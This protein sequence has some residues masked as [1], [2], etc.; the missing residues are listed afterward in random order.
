MGSSIAWN[1]NSSGF[2]YIKFD[3]PHAGTEATAVAENPKI[4]FHEIGTEQ[5]KDVLIWQNPDQKNWIY[6]IQTSEDGKYLI[7]TVNEG[8]SIE[9]KIFYKELSNPAS[10]IKRLL[11]NL[12]AGHTYL[13][14][15][16]NIF[17]FIQII[18]PRTAE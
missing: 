18:T 2:Y 1:K 3:E 9:T 16:D 11:S 13:G 8:S 5:S 17:Y 7:I 10:Q 14:N 6:F 12:K 15:E 4:L